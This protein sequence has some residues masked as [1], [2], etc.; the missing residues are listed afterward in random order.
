MHMKRKLG[1]AAWLATSLMSIYALVD[2]KSV[3]TET[4]INAGDKVS[5]A[6]GVAEVKG[7]MAPGGRFEYLDSLERNEVTTRLNDMQALYDKFGTV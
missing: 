4:I 5:F 6:A 1:S 7:E 3:K 2:A